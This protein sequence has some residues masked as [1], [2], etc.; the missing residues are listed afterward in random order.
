MMFMR[1]W[2]AYRIVIG[3]DGGTYLVRWYSELDRRHGTP[4]W[5]VVRGVGDAALEP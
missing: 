3:L 2:I 5:A 1:D 4:H